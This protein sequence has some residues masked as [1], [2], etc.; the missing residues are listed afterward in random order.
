MGNSTTELTPSARASFTARSSPVFQPRRDT[1][2]IDSIGMSS[3]PSWMKTGRRRLAGVRIV[4]VMALRMVGERR[5]R[6][7]RE[8]RSCGFLI[9]D[10]FFRSFVRSSSLLGLREREDDKKKKKKREIGLASSSSSFFFVSSSSLVFFSCYFP[11]L[12]AITKNPHLR[13]DDGSTSRDVGLF[14]LI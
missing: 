2:G 8:G 9:I 5:L 4:S 10:V 6:R 7:G 1:P 13:R 14:E 3:S 11:H 12:S